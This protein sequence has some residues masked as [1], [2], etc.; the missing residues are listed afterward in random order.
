MKDSIIIDGNDT[1]MMLA[2]NIEKLGVGHHEEIFSDF[3]TCEFFLSLAFTVAVVLVLAFV[4]RKK[5]V[6]PKIKLGK[7]A[8]GVWLLG[9]VLYIIG[10]SEGGTKDSPALFLRSALSSLEMFVSHSDLIEVRHEC[11][12]NFV[13]MLVFSIVHFAA[14]LLSVIFILRTF[15]YKMIVKIGLR[16]R[17][18]NANNVYIF[19]G[20]ND[21]AKVLAKN[22]KDKENNLILFFK[23]RENS[24]SSHRLSF[25]SFFGINTISSEDIELAENVNGLVFY[26]DDKDYTK[27]LSKIFGK[28][29]VNIITEIDVAEKE[30]QEKFKTKFADKKEEK[31]KLA[32]G[33]KKYRDALKNLES[34]KFGIFVLSDDEQANFSDI[35]MLLNTECVQQQYYNISIYCHAH[36]SIE[37]IAFE[38]S[39]LKKYKG[40]IELIDS[41]MLSVQS[42]IMHGAEHPV[43]FVDHNDAGIVT[44]DF[45]AL[46]LGFGETSQE[47][48]SFLYEYGAFLG[49][50]GC[51]SGFHC[52][53]IDSKMDIL[54]GSYLSARPAIENTQLLSFEK[55]AVGSVDYW[56]YIDHIVEKLNY[57]VIALGNDN[58]NIASAIEL[59][60][61]CNRKRKGNLEKFKIYVRVHDDSNSNYA[62]AI[63]DYYGIKHIHMFGNYSS[64]FTEDVIINSE[65]KQKAET[66]YN[67]YE[68]VK[69]DEIFS[70]NT[71][72]ERR[73]KE[74]AVANNQ[75]IADSSIKRKETQDL[76]NAYHIHTKAKLMGLCDE[77][78]LQ[79]FKAKG[80]KLN[81]NMINLAKKDAVLCYSQ[82]KLTD[83]EIPKEDL[84]YEILVTNMA[85][86][87]HL[88]WNAAHEMLGYTGNPN[89]KGCDETTKEHNCL[90][91][92][93]QLVEKWKNSGYD[94]WS[95]YRQ[96]DYTVVDT[97]IKLYKPTEDKAQDQ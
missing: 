45:N 58:L 60:E 23:K 61:Y 42:L 72:K 55:L 40:S 10:F 46:V 71:R 76:S 68:K 9:W 38:K 83:V 90:V 18:R 69:E 1:L 95:E 48:L 20:I 52:S 97:T 64:I 36:R 54:K 30:L 77:V 7:I 80:C 93:E 53:V 84:E 29:D 4:F 2:K 92:W 57:V 14:V 67:T 74:F 27:Q 88:R 15:F 79:E 11:H 21:A 63:E 3:F 22:I 56:R 70:V 47:V 16:K 37:N 89:L 91:S 78:R 5:I 12:E 39:C 35:N 66:Y 75:L 82:G 13:Y 28:A 44:S 65:M 17:V 24:H 43:N 34:K 26:Y 6:S 59:F 8:L 49:E 73:I 33:R 81:S 51:R 96:Y 50:N 87:E 19:W 86:L 25:I 62:K 85:K 31:E 41:S 94:E 32:A